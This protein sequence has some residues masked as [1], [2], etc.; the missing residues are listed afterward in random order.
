MNGL[1]QEIAET[2]PSLTVIPMGKE[3]SRGKISVKLVGQITLEDAEDMNQVDD[4][5]R[6]LMDSLKNPANLLSLLK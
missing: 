3:A 1:Q 2:I 6:Q 4:K 5:V